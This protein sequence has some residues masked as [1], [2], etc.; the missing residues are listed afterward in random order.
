MTELGDHPGH[1]EA[2]QLPSFAGFGALSDFDFN[3]TALVQIFG[4]D[5]ETS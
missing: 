3:L 2:G 1:L 4:R 5:T